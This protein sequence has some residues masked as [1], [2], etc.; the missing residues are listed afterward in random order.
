MYYDYCSKAEIIDG[1]DVIVAG[2]GPAG[3]SAAVA[4]AR[5]GS[6]V[7]LVERYG[8]LG[9]NLT[10]GFVGPILGMVS[11]GTMRDELVSLLGVSGND[12]IGR[13]GVAHDMEK[14]KS[15]LASFADL[16][17]L[18]VYLQCAAI[19]AIMEGSAIKGLVI[20]SKEGLKALMG[21]IVIDCTGD[22]DIAFHAGAVIEKGRDDGLMQPVTLEFRVAGL[23]ESRAITCIGDV[24]DVRFGGMRFL[25]YCASC[26]EKGELPPSLAAVRLHKT[27]RPGERQVNT[28]QL[29]GI[30]ST[31]TED[32]FT[33]EKELRKQIGIV[34]EFLRT[35]LP[36]Y[37][38]CYVSESGTTLGVR[39]SRR[40]IGEYVMTE[41]DIVNGRRFE[42]AIV[43]DADFIV[44]IHNPEGAGQAEERIQYARPYDIPYRAFVPLGIDNLYTAGRC[45]SGTH[46]AHA[47]YRV[48][49]ICM[50]MGEAVGV[51]ASIASRIG[52]SPRDLDYRLVQ[53][54]LRKNGID[55]FS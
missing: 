45:I 31:R 6:R 48:M 54:E 43:H 12:M 55:L 3:I 20:S 15:V 29:N 41:D 39:E 23:D 49:S 25:D 24:D 19:D 11:K 4:A 10:A 33:S 26:A 38:N 40:V 30:D 51:A 2:S 9:G 53:E 46:K 14:A 52:A 32:I 42:D 34:T 5:K 47:S 1:Y 50:A 7:A 37:E 36:G 27:A 44:D 13:V 8:V 35:H 17:N 18:D 28:T 21:S 22:G 16:P